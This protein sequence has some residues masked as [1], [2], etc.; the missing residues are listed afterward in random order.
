MKT[1]LYKMWLEFCKNKHCPMLDEKKLP[2]GQISGLVSFNAKPREYVIMTRPSPEY[3]AWRA[4]MKAHDPDLVLAFIVKNFN[5]FK[6]SFPSGCIYL[7][8]NQ[9]K[10]SD[11]M[12]K[13][14]RKTQSEFKRALCN[15]MQE[16]DKRRKSGVR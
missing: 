15:D 1:K 11:V 5:T 12:K 3:D 9:A 16:R 7:D 6:D 8:L 2:S 10:V 14:N 4:F 13:M